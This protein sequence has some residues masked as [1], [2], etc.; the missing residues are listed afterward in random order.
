MPRGEAFV[1]QRL[2]KGPD[3][4]NI[5]RATSVAREPVRAPAGSFE[6]PVKERR[7]DSRRALMIGAGF[8]LLSG[9]FIAIAQYPAADSPRKAASARPSA[10]S[11]DLVSGTITL[12]TTDRRCRKTTFDAK[13][14]H[15]TEVSEIDR[16]CGSEDYAPPKPAVNSRIDAIGRS[17]VNR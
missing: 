5:R 4:G 6:P 11:N 3:H 7:M 8:L 2:T 15:V 14:G 13:S 9:T 10:D 17:F 16:P 12:K 1:T